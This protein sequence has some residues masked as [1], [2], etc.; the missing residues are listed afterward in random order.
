MEAYSFTAEQLYD[1][2][3]TE[4]EDFLL[5]D[6]RNNEEFG[7]FS[8]EGPFLKQMINVPYFEFLEH[9]DE[10][11]KKVPTREKIKIV[12]AKEGSAKY[13]AD[14][15]L[16]LG[17]K[18]VGFLTGGIGT[19]ADLL[20]PQLI[21]ENDRFSLFQFIRPGKASLSYGLVCEE[22]C[23]IF[24]PARLVNVY[25]DFAKSHNIKITKIFETHL[26]A[27]YI[28]G[29]QNLSAIAQ[30]QI[31]AHKDDYG[32]A[33]FKYNAV[34]NGQ[35][36]KSANGSV[37]VKVIH[38]PGHTP[39]STSYLIDDRFLI[40]GDAVF[41]KSIGRPDLGGKVE[42][43]SGFLFDTIQ[44]VLKKI[45]DKVQ[46]MPGHYMDWSEMTSEGLFIDSLGHIMETNNKIY[47]LEDVKAFTAFIKENMRP[48]PGVYAEIRK[49]NAG[50]LDPPEDEQI[51]MD[52]GKNECAATKV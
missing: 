16:N 9:E 10:S 51:I 47:S 46:V 19:W 18:D 7:K 50:L 39:G 48:Q 25:L 3:F 33:S 2:I 14:I 23:F 11:I 36:I 4:K 31:F 34:E 24:D 27:D 5:V 30:A 44:N 20:K 38:T 26:Q 40:S 29:S 45:D 28:S 17:F 49:V 6:V 15:L 41:I 21:E 37:D 8:V 42:E 35:T 13:V 52:I 1:A 22:E 43:W 32:M 12:C